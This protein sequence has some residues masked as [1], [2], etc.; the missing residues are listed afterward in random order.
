[1]GE[2]LRLVDRA[3]DF[4]VTAGGK[5]ISPSFVESAMRASPYIAEI[6]VF[7][8]GRRYLS[9]LVEIDF[10][11]VADWARNNEI[12]YTGFTNLAQNPEV[13]EL[14]KAEIDKANLQL[15]RVEQIK[16]FRILPKMLDPGG[17]GRTGHADPQGQARADVRA[18]QAPGGRDVRRPGGTLVGGRSGRRIAR[19]NA[20]AELHETAA[21]GETLMRSLIFAAA[22]LA[23][24]ISGIRTVAAPRTPTWSASPRR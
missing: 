17:R 2:T 21:Q 19:M 24:L 4:I 23:A 7:G 1:M 18:V 22:T 15:A 16:A 10:D 12:N 5:T 9:A 3:R 20:Q 6:A 8:Q 11:M 13:E 14:I